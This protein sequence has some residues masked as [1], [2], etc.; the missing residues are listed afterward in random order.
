MDDICRQGTTGR[1]SDTVA[2]QGLLFLCEVPEDLGGDLVAQAAEVLRFLEQRLAAGGSHKG[3]LLSATIYL[4]DPADLAD[5]NRLWEA[6]L[7]A[8]TAPVR[9]CLHASLTDPR[10]RVEIQAIAAASPG[11]NP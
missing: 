5:F 6:W 2:W 3:R 8:G 11:P 4:P 10:M 1:W 7:P 9:A